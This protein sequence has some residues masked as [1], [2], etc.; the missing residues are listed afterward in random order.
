MQELSNDV[1]LE[2]VKR[3]MGGDP[4]AFALLYEDGLRRV[5]AFAA[6]RCATRE[7]AEAITEAILTRAFATLSCFTGALSW[8]VWLGALAAELW[9]ETHGTPPPAAG[10]AGR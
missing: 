3:A 5:W 8:P 2:E 4:H 7:A 10:D 6:R 9:Q 1:G